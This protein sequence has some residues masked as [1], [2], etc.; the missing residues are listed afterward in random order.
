M[1]LSGSPL[2]NYILQER[3]GSGGY[4]H[5]FRA[6]HRKTGTIAA[7]KVLE[8]DPD[9]P[10]SHEKAIRF[11]QEIE[12]IT[13]MRHAHIVKVFEAGWTPEAVYIA[14]EYLA[15]GTLDDLMHKRQGRP[16]SLGETCAMMCQV[17]DALQFAHS[18]GVVHRDI[19]P[20]NILVS[21]QKPM[22]LVL[23]DFGIAKIMG[24]S[25]FTA[26]DMTVGTPEYMAPEQIIFGGQVS[27]RTDLYSVACVTYELLT[28][29]LPFDG[30]LNTLLDRHVNATPRPIRTLNPQ[31]PQ[32]VA[33]ILDQTLQKAPDS[34]YA[35]AEIMHIALRPFANGA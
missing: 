9:H 15:H 29:R 34:R 5:V 33:L 7:V 2:G 23:S 8:L 4:A 22:T 6:C 12:I 10:P 32:P 14:M 16:F 35:T 26:A 30:Q 3:I 25:G 28:G 19:K 21:Q 27:A 24:Q 13:H 20:A 18:R 11:G 1:D 31:V 17:L